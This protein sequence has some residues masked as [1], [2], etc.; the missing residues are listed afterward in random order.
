METT[1]GKYDV[2]GKVFAELPGESQGKLVINSAS[3]VKNILIC[4]VQNHQKARN[5]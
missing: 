4:K 2:F 5:V 1:V 3:L